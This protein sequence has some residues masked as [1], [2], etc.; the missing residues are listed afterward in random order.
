[1]VTWGAHEGLSTLPP[2]GHQGS[3]EWGKGETHWEA[4]SCF[5]MKAA[6]CYAAR[7]A[8]VAATAATASVRVQAWAMAVGT[9]LWLRVGLVLVL[10][11]PSC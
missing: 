4:A 11:P 3:R 1:M 8:G 6:V 2:T 5:T 7:P 10:L 9:S